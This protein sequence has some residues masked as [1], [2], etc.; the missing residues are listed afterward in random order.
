MSSRPD[1]DGT[2]PPVDSRYQRILEYPDARRKVQL[3]S[4]LVPAGCHTILDVG[5][6]TG[7]P[8]LG[9]RRQAQVVTVDLSM[10]S[11]KAGEGDRALAGAGRLPFASDSFDLV[12]SSQVLEYLPAATYDRALPEMMRVAAKYLLVSVSYRE[13]LLAR[14]VRC[15]HCGEVYHT[16]QHVRAFTE[17]SLAALFPGWLLA[18]WHV[19]G[20]LDRH[21]GLASI[22]DGAAPDERRVLPPAGEDSVCPTCGKP[23]GEPRRE[24]LT[25]RLRT[26]VKRGFS[27]PAA[28]PPVEEVATFLP[29]HK[30]PY[31]VAALYEPIE[32]ARALDGDLAGFMNLWTKAE[33]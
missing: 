6:G 14:M 20:I 30:A 26:A 11:L 24:G 2:F 13:N 27:R 29:Q 17:Q 12:M 15:P 8:T 33:K 22:G 16:R 10:S 21:T 31:W 25:G 28:P 4:A 9:M 5:G 19:F 3:F 32:G 23:G 18:E 1:N 7:W